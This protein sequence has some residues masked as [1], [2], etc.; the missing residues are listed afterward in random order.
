MT[1]QNQSKPAALDYYEEIIQGLLKLHKNNGDTDITPIHLQNTALA[2][3][4]E[5]IFLD[6]RSEW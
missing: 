1:E 2:I 3:L 6:T 5:Q 4:K